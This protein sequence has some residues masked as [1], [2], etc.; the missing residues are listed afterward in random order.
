MKGTKPRR[1]AVSAWAG[2]RAAVS[3]PVRRSLIALLC[4]LA[5][6]TQNQIAQTHL[7]VS[8]ARA[9]S[10]LAANVQAGST[11]KLPLPDQGQDTP[12]KCPLCQVSASLGNL[13]NISALI[14]AVPGGGEAVAPIAAVL[15]AHESSPGHV[16]RSRGPPQH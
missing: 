11:H 13:L 7:H 8:A 15:T 16:W 3:A 1:R 6:A 2:V 12:A 5:F 14:I 10:V 9:V 4:I